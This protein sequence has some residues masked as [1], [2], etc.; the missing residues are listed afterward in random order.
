MSTNSANGTP[1]PNCNTPTT[2]P[3]NMQNPQSNGPGGM[4]MNAITN[5]PNGSNWLDKFNRPVAHMTTP[6]MPMH[7]G[8]GK[9]HKSKHRA[10]RASGGG[11]H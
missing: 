6:G 11:G 7:Y 5:N 2:A 4:E 3:A 9:H 10:K 1:Y 8:M